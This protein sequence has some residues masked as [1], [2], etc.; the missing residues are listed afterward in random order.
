MNAAV[1]TAAVVA[2]P[3]GAL[4]GR[5]LDSVAPR[6]PRRSPLPAGA[7]IDDSPVPSRALGAPLPEMAGGLL[8]GL[9]V[10]RFGLTP[11]LA[12]WLWFA[13]IGLLLAVVDLREK[14]LP[15][16]VLVPGTAITAL[17]LAVVA[18]V[19]GTWADLV[20]ALIAAAVSFAVLL[21]MAVAAPAGLGMGDAKLAGLLGLVLGW[22][23]WPSVLFG[24]LL[25]FVAQA[26]VGL[27]LMALRRAGRRTEL[28][29]GPALLAGA[30]VAALL[31]GAWGVHSG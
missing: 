22:L 19:E 3:L 26:V 15:N 10:L 24:F 7:Q 14:L 27:T 16:R 17:L 8:V 21:A 9:L 12:A 5:A 2:L 30:L 28:P 25:G 20:R 4:A 11:Q 1:V 31:A 18:A 23:G 6:V 29:F 13:L